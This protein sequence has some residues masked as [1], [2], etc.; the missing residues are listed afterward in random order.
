MYTDFIVSCMLSIKKHQ[1][2]Y[3]YV[4][5]LISSIYYHCQF[6]LVKEGVINKLFAF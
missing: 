6:V 1:I 4:G 3:V 2:V 5:G